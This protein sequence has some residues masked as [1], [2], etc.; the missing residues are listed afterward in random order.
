MKTFLNT[1]VTLGI[2]LAGPV[3]IYPAASANAPSTASGSS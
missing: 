1:S 3:M 2:L